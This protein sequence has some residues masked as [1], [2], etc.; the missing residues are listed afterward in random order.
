[1]KRGLAFLFFL[2]FFLAALGWAV[3]AV[4][5][6][7]NENYAFVGHYEGGK[8]VISNLS[9]LVENETFVLTPEELANYTLEDTFALNYS[10]LTLSSVLPFIVKDGSSNTTMRDLLLKGL[11]LPARQIA[12]K[13]YQVLENL[14]GIMKIHYNNSSCV[15]YI[16]NPEVFDVKMPYKQLNLTYCDFEPDTYDV[17]YTPSGEFNVSTVSRKVD[18]RVVVGYVKYDVKDVDQYDFDICYE[19]GYKVDGDLHT[20]VKR[21]RYGLGAGTYRFDGGYYKG[22]GPLAELEVVA[23]LHT[24]CDVFYCYSYLTI[25]KVTPKKRTLIFEKDS[26]DI[27][28]KGTVYN[29]TSPIYIDIKP[30]VEMVGDYVENLIAANITFTHGSSGSVADHFTEGLWGYEEAVVNYSVFVRDKIDVYGTDVVRVY[31][32]GYFRVHFTTT[33]KLPP[34][35][36]TAVIPSVPEIIE[37]NLTPVPRWV[38]EPQ[39]IDKNYAKEYLNYQVSRWT[40]DKISEFL[41]ELYGSSFD[42]KVYEAWYLVGHMA[43]L[44]VRDDNRTG[45]PYEALISGAGNTIQRGEI[46]PAVMSFLTYT[47]YRHTD[48][49]W[50]LPKFNGSGCQ[51]GVLSM[52]LLDS[53]D[54]AQSK[55]PPTLTPVAFLAGDMKLLLSEMGVQNSYVAVPYF[56]TSWGS[57]DS[58]SEFPKSGEKISLKLGYYNTSTVFDYRPAEKEVI[59][60]K[61]YYNTSELFELSQELQS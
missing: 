8:F 51:E 12:P 41:D 1:M 10:R 11:S 45:Y 34:W 42:Y 21:C 54:I 32:A 27:F 57:V 7:L 6:W 22:W 13:Q 35:G 30:A 39:K 40:A 25:D 46:L 38:F 56:I 47:G 29:G 2:I 50:Y 59:F 23:K 48:V 36:E 3:G 52:F 44:V 16:A 49:Y 55:Y 31:P 37:T 4:A 60:E 28:L 26:H 33:G 58:I 18:S 15:S 61:Y 19:L 20:E 9:V 5:E 24:H 17:P 14:T 53:E 43:G